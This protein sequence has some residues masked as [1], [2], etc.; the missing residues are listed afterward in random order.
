MAAI[1]TKFDTI[2]NK[3]RGKIPISFLRSLSYL[4]S[5]MN[6]NRSIQNSAGLFMISLPVLKAYDKAFPNQS[7][8]GGHKATDLS[9][10]ILNTKIALW[11]INRIVKY[12]AKNYPKT[13]SENWND[14]TYISLIVHGF[15][16]GYTEPKGIGAAIKKIENEAPKK[17][18]IDNVATI[19]KALGLNK[20]KY[21]E[22]KINFAKNVANVYFIDSGKPTSKIVMTK[23]AGTGPIIMMGAAIAGLVVALV[24]GR[25]K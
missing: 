6:T 4:K 2:F 10:P 24:K 25:K 8:E 3:F 15:N 21:D 9:D 20:S 7:P 18:T 14:A 23:E 19:S 1:P 11:I 16:T 13:L 5:S 17:M 22:R 12:Y